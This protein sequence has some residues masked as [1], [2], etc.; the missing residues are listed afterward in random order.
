MGSPFTVSLKFYGIP[1]KVWALFETGFEKM[2][3]FGTKG[4]L[5]SKQN[6]W[7]VTSPKKRSKSTSHNKLKW[8]VVSFHQETKSN[9]RVWSSC[10]Q[11]GGVLADFWVPNE[12]D[13]LN[14][15]HMLLFWFREASPNL[16]LFRKMLKNCHNYILVF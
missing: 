9:E 16:S 11:L 1:K 13:S 10:P 2:S 7:A 15:Q 3:I 14:F 4:Q 12:I 6:C 8:C 5:I